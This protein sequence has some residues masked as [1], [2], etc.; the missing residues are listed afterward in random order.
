VSIATTLDGEQP[1]LPDFSGLTPD[2]FVLPHFLK[3]CD[4]PRFLQ[5]LIRSRQPDVVLLSNSEL[6]YLLLP[7]LRTFCPEPAYVDYC[8]MEEEYW[9]NGGYPGY[10]AAR[11]HYLDL[12]IVSSEHLKRWMTG[13]GADPARIEVCHTNQDADAWAP[14]PQERRRIRAEHRIADDEPVLLFA[15]RLCSQKKPRVLAQ[16]ARQLA[17]RKIDF[18]LLVAGGGEDEAW[19]ESFLAEHHLGDRVL[20]LGPVPSDCMPALMAAADIYFLPSLW[21]GIALSL[22]EAMAVGLAVVGAD[23]GG[24][25]ELVTPECGVLIDPGPDDREIESYTETLTA[26]LAQPDRVR[27]MGRCGRARIQEHFR[28]SAMGDRMVSLFDLAR[29]LKPTT[30]RQPLDERLVL[31]GTAMSVEYARACAEVEENWRH[32]QALANRM[33]PWR[34]L[35]ETRAS[36]IESLRRWVDEL[37]RAKEWLDTQR[38]SWQRVAHTRERAIATSREWI[39]ELESGKAWLESQLAAWQQTAGE[40]GAALADANRWISELERAKAWLE[41]QRLDWKTAAEQHAREE[42]CLRARVAELERNGPPHRGILGRLRARVSQTSGAAD[43]VD[44]NGRE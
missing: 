29:H 41:Q 5:Y 36:E 22:F 6:A 27:E 44:P 2:V 26:L 34:H 24:Q 3:R 15:G 23:V 9:K 20:M 37:E 35:A 14:D 18:R 4:F 10:S 38:R 7:F 25:R 17:A 40:R 28:L 32:R 39:G 21:E 16:V 19:F 43:N 8:H 12:N 1:W 11:Q 31:E 30:Q 13:R 33:E 42:E